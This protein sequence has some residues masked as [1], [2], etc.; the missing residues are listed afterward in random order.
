[1]SR[2]LL[3]VNFLLALAWPHHQFHA[4]AE[5]WFYRNQAKGW[6]T[7]AVTQLGFIRLSSNRA[8]LGALA[9]TPE[10]AR[11]LMEALTSDPHH[12]FLGDL[13]AP[14]AMKEIAK[15]FG[16]QQVTD[17]YLIGVA[18]LSKSKLVTFDRQLAALAGDKS[19]L[20]ILTPRL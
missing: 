19:T 7:C 20:E 9:K 2:A 14:V 12:A 5:E 10:E 4:T 16:H 8:Y 13:K 6:V 11:D 3:D 15:L 17:A 1:M 18:R